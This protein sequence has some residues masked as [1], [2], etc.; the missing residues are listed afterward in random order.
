MLFALSL[1]QVK[2]NWVS[3]G[4]DF[5]DASWSSKLTFSS[6]FGVTV[7]VAAACAIA[8]E[9]MPGSGLLIASSAEV[10]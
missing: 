10:S 5:F 4:D 3:F 6:P 8:V 7:G 2:V 9:M 1:S